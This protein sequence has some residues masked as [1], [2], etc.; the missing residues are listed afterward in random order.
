VSIV[1]WNLKEAGCEEHAN[2]RTNLWSDEQESPIRS[3]MRVRLQDKSKQNRLL[4]LSCHN[5][6]F[7]GKMKQKARLAGGIY[8]EEAVWYNGMVHTGTKKL[9]S[10][11]S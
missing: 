3:C 8:R 6:K 1:R 7:Y 9:Q 5:H 4:I 10:I 11:S 2:S